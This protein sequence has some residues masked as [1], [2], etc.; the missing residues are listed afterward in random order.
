[1]SGSAGLGGRKLVPTI[2][3]S[4]SLRGQYILRYYITADLQ[5]AK[6]E[7]AFPE[8]RRPTRKLVI[9]QTLRECEEWYE[10]LKACKSWSVDIEVVNFEVSAIG[11][12]PQPDIGISIPMYHSHWTLQEET[13][14][15]WMMNSLL[16][17]ENITKIFQNGIFD[18][19]FLA[20][21][22][23]IHVAPPIEDTMIA[24]S[25]MYPEMRK[26]LEFLVSMYCGSQKYYKD[27]VKFDNIKE[28][29]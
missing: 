7:S 24:H 2:H 10:Y 15:W 23:G 28:D 27:M 16:T 5:K 18:V 20:V 3:P 29:A 1:M 12:A 17:D 14:V 8:I 25:I 26:S 21:Q 13:R 22:N 6:R 4:S 19:H 11:F 9:P